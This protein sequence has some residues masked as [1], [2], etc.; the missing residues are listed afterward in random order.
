MR[1]LLL[2]LLLFALPAS[3]DT[4]WYPNPED[5]GSP[6]TQISPGGRA[7]YY[8]TGASLE[9]SAFL[10]LNKCK[11]VDVTVFTSNGV[12]AA[13]LFTNDKTT[14]ANSSRLYSDA[15]DVNLQGTDATNGGIY[16]IT[17]QDNIWVDVV[18]P[19]GASQWIMFKAVCEAKE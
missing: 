9:K 5:G 16:K 8:H 11:S 2:A 4:Q 12:G 13:Q 1:T 14:G 17:G 19:P 3:A 6:L 18:T 15:G 7:F 10:T